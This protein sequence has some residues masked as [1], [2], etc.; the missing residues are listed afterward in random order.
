MPSQKDPASLSLSRSWEEGA[1]ELV[2]NRI[3]EEDAATE[4]IR[5]QQIP[6]QP[7]LHARKAGEPDGYGAGTDG[8]PSR[9][10]STW[11]P[12]LFGSET[13]GLTTR[14]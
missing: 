14:G 2:I 9:S 11:E 1:A 13:R 8:E 12:D 3:A 6:A 5:A 4:A 7:G 10:S